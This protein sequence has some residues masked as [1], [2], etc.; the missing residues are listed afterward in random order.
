MQIIEEIK[1]SLDGFAKEKFIKCLEKKYGLQ[2]YVN[3]K[4]IIWVSKKNMI[5]APLVSVPVERIFSRYKNILSE[6][7]RIYVYLIFM[8]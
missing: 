4:K 2:K 6:Q 1:S 7:R 3:N 5:Y 8:F